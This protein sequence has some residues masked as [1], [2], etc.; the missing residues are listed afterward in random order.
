LPGTYNEKIVRL[1]DALFRL[2]RLKEL[3]LSRN[4]I[5]SLEGL[6]NLKQ[7]EKLNLY[8]CSTN[9]PWS[10]FSI[11]IVYI[12]TYR[13]YNNVF[14]LKELE[15]LSRNKKLLEL[16]LRLNPISKEEIDYRLYLIYILPT[17]RLLDDREIRENEKHMT[18]AY[19]NLKPSASET[20][21]PVHSANVV[22]SR[23]VKSVTNIM[24]RSAGNGPYPRTIIYFV[25]GLKYFR[26]FRN[27]KC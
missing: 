25:F 19:F 14:S 20:N 10:Y 21:V 13:Y 9:L 12:F 15:R 5:S 18:N 17:L 27:Q 26:F 24:K 23:R 1:G 22:A 7:L 16:D 11:K 3:D 8:I 4:S 6:E 2:T